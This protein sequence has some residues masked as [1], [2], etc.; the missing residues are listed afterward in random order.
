MKILSCFILL[1]I[2]CEHAVAQDGYWQQE[3]AY[4]IDVRL[5]D[6]DNT[7]DGFLRLHYVNHSPDTLSFIWFHLW[8]NAFKNDRTAFSE[9]RLENGK[10]DFY[11]SRKEERGYMNRLDFRANG[12]ALKTEDHPLY[13][14]V[15]KVYLDAPLMPGQATTLETPFHVKLPFNFSRGGYVGKSFQLTQWYPKP[16][17]YDRSG[18]HPMPY[19]DQGEFYGEFG[20]FDVRI[21]VPKQYVV[22]ATGELQG[23]DEKKWLAERMPPAG[24]TATKKAVIKQMI[25]PKKKPAA[26]KPVA[27]KPAARKPIAKKQQKTG[28]TSTN[29]RNTI[30]LPPA[31]LQRPA[32][33]M[34]TLRFLQDHVHDFAW[35][36]DTAFIADHDTIQLASGRVVQAYSFYHPAGRE[37]W[38][39]SIAMIKDAIHFHSNLIGE[40]P[41]STVSAVEAS[42]GVNGGMEYPTI[43]SISPMPDTK[44]LDQILSHEIGHNWFYG[45]LGTNE[46]DNP[47][48]DEGINTYYDYRYED[49]KYGHAQ[50][51]RG[52]DMFSVRSSL[53]KV[54]INTLAKE[55]KDQP[56]AGT[57]DTFTEVNYGLMVYLKTGYWMKQ[58][59]DTLGTTVMD[60]AM[61]SYF[62][63]WKFRHPQPADFRKAM[64]KAAN[65]DLSRHF[66][67][68]YQR[69]P[70]TEEHHPKRI[71]AAFALNLKHTDSTTYVNF[72]P[73]I[74]INAYDGFMV[75]AALHNFNLPRNKLEFIAVPMYAAR[76]KQFSGI[77]AVHYS[78]YPASKLEKISIGLAAERF[79]SLKGIDSNNARIFGGFTKLAPFLRL[80]LANSKARSTREKWVEWRTF[81]IGERGFDYVL[82]QSDSTYYPTKGSVVNRYVNQLTFYIGDY[83]ALYPFDLQLQV[84]QGAG[85]YR[86]TATANGFFNYASGGGA[87]VRVFAGKFGFIGSKTVQKEFDTYAYQPKL[88]AVRGNEDFTYGNYFVGRNEIDGIG[89][90]QIMIR[91][92]ALKIRTDLFQGLQGR[93]ENWIAALNFNTSLPSSVLPSVIPLKI[94]FD[95]GT[96]AEAWKKDAA[97]SRFLFVSG[98]QLSLFKDFLNIYAPILYS[99]E[100]RDNLKTVPEEN[101]FLKKISFSIDIQRFNLRR[102]SGNRLPL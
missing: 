80:T 61:K 77:G 79:S 23:D 47:W 63:E 102:L 11:F 26:T 14:D 60:D 97:T 66:D 56:V 1:F 22:A 20:S 35:F 19:L 76:S 95:F 3:V 92:G 81:V 69:G 13:I 82:R 16:A 15:I 88:T 42:T 46:R 91:D 67:R 89:S 93:S 43:T 73:A 68:L 75:G 71:R 96:Y 52:I 7:L 87:N 101:K 86:A 74:G 78:W 5:D 28:L 6:N 65:R 41:Y 55:K 9:Q 27:K 83:R 62:M 17:V 48:M 29:N 54:L 50:Q 70:I 12:I 57:A 99:S 94:F 36:A 33:Q 18:W 21:T 32:Q 59:E 37:V 90:Q 85:F 84:Q 58:L 51:S 31:P 34:K 30:T 4:T 49:W 98:L 64:E 39:S 45:A 10:T 100:F 25:T 44:S 24:A 8:P 2:C 40:Y 53:G 38:E 72:F